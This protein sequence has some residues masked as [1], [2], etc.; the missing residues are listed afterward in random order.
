MTAEHE[1]WRPVSR[2]GSFEVSSFGQV[3]WADSGKLKP[4]TLA[5][6]GFLVVN[7]YV[8]GISS[9]RNVHSVV[10]EAFLGPR[11]AGWMVAHIDEDRLHNHWRNLEYR[12]LGE[13]RAKSPSIQPGTNGRIDLSQAREILRRANLGAAT[14]DLAEQFG[15]SAP[16][17]SGIKS[18]RKWRVAGG[19]RDRIDV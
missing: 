17:V 7:L 9:V 5:C 8:Q 1:T 19:N 10:A 4:L 6:S 3:R 18:G 12:K 16:M 14:I 13:R 15:I 11:P 2:L